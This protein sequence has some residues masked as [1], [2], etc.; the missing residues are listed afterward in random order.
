[1]EAVPEVRGVAGTWW[2]G[3]DSLIAIYRGEAELFQRPDYRTA[4]VHSG[5]VRT[6]WL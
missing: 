2:L 1:M 3:T 4:Y 5:F 6:R